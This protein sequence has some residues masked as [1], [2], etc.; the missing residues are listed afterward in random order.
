MT[1]SSITSEKSGVIRRAIGLVP[2]FH[3]LRTYSWLKFRCDLFAGLTVA[4]VAV[5][6]AMAYA[7]IFGMPP[8]YGLYTAIVMTAVG[9]LL[10]GSRHLINGPTNAISIAMLSALAVV[11]EDQR[12]PAA[13]MMAL[14]VGTIQTA[15]TIFKLGDLSKYISSA[16]VV[17]FT[18]G[19]SVLLLMDQF[20]NLAGLKYKADPHHHFVKRFYETIV[21][22]G[23]PHWLTL[24]LALLTILVVLLCRWINRR[25]K[26]GLPELLLGIVAAGLFVWIF[27]LDDPTFGLA[28]AGKV[29]TTLPSFQ[30]PMLDWSLAS[31]LASSALAIAFLGLLEA[32]AMAKSLAAKS[33]QKLDINQQCLSEG[34][35]NIVGSFFSCFPG[36]G[37]LTRSYINF[38]S[39]AKTQWSGVISALGVAIT[40]VALGPLAAYIPKSALA[41]VLVLTAMR[42]VEIPALKFHWKATNF[43]RIILVATGLSAVLISIEFCILIGVLLS[44]LLYVPRAV[45]LWMSE[46]TITADRKVRELKP[47]DQHCE[48]FRIYNLEGELFFGCAPEFETLLEQITKDTSN[49][50]AVILLRTKRL[51]NPDAMCLEILHKWVVATQKRGVS[52][53]LSGVRPDLDRALKNLGIDTLIGEANIF[54]ES[55]ELYF[56]TMQAMQRGYEILGQRRCQNCPKQVPDNAWSYDI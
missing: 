41:G 8:Q 51:H 38:T 17:G 34:V 47:N 54:R 21:H 46:L 43:D 1:N 33:E 26:V 37:S 49:S 11:P 42:M 35:A 20:K 15:I 25:W 36:S 13:F 5:P 24:T 56:S 23:S 10:N 3:E 29:P 45:R 55:Q 19:A 44:F 31:E 52:I 27:R 7:T 53:L 40:M 50:A 12:V 48:Y 18:C 22:S 6:Q 28:L 2:A 9:S 30:R 14:I 32:I 39:G 4:A 16:V